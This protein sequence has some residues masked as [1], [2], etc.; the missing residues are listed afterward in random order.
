MKKLLWLMPMG[1]CLSLTACSE[2]DEAYYLKH[3]DEAKTKWAQCEKDA[4][5]AMRSRDKSTLETLMADGSEC[6]LARN[7]IKEDKRLQREKE[8]NE[9]KAKLAADIAQAK[10]QLKQQYDALPWQEFVK[11]YVN[12]T[13]PSS[14][15]TTPECEAMKAFYQEKTLPVITELRTKGLAN[16]LKEEQNYCK[17]DK[18]QYSTCD[19]WQTAVKEQATEE[20]QAMTLEQLDALKAYDDDYKKAQP[21]GAWREVFKQK[22]DAYITQLVSNYDQLKTIYNNCLDQ[23]KSTQNWEK[24]YKITSSYPCKQA[25]HARIKLQLPSDNFQTHME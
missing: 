23:V 25:S 4:E 18:R 22:E 20:F 14:W 9:R 21:R 7:A 3:I 11:A 6:N 12:S 10:A 16:L 1:V 8:E 15:K 5:A 17:Q 2:K 24:Q 13:C 19:V